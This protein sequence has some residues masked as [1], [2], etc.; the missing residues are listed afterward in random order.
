MVHPVLCSIP[1]KWKLLDDI[2]VN[3]VAKVEEDA[4][5]CMGKNSVCSVGD[6]MEAGKALCRFDQSVRGQEFLD[7]KMGKLNHRRS[8]HVHHG[9]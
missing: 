4:E 2:F 5:G 8:V 3:I 9:N 6:D 1:S 7:R